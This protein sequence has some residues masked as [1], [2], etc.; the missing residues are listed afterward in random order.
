MLLDPIS[1]DQTNKDLGGVTVT[2]QKPF[3]ETKIDRTVVN[4]D[5]S[6]TSVGAT[7]LDILEKSPGIMVNHD[8]LISL[9]GK[10]GVIVMMDGKQTFLSPADLTNLLRNTPAS[11]LDQI[12]I[13]TNPSSKFD[14]AGNS[15]IINI[16]TKK[17]RAAGF[18][19]SVM[20]GATTSIYNLDGKTLFIPKSQ[21]SI[22]FNY[23]KNKINFFG[24]YN[25]NFFRGRNTMH[26]DT[27]FLNND[28]ELT[29]YGTTDTRFIF[30]GDNHTL[31]LGLDVF[32]NK[33][34]V[35]GV[36]VSGFTF[37]GRPKPTTVAD[38]FSATGQLENR[39]VSFTE[40]Q[41]R[42][43]NFTGNA[44]WK[45]NFDSVGKELTMDF[46]YVKYSSETDM[47]LTTNY[48]DGNLQST[49]R[50]F[51]KGNLPSEIDIYS[52][53]T[54]FVM[55][56]K[57]GRFEAGVKISYV[58]ND[59]LVDYERSFDEQTWERDNIRSNHFIYKE[60]INAG[61]VT[62]NKKIKKWTVQGGLRV[63]N[64]I[65]EGHQIISNTKFRR[66]TTNFFPTAFVSYALSDKNTFTVNYGRR[67]TRPNYQDLNPFIFFL[68]TLSYRK[69]NIYLKPQ[70]THNVE[71]THAF[72]GKFITTLNYNHTDNV[73]SQIVKPESGFSKIRFLTV[74]NVASFR[75]IGIAL[76]TPVTIAEWW[77]TNIF[78]NVFNNRFKGVVDTFAVDVAFTSF[79]INV[80]N[81]FTIAKGF[82]AELSGF[83]RHKGLN[84]LSIAEPV[85]QMGFGLQKQIMKTKG[86]IRLNVRDPFAW[87]VFRGL[88]KY[89]LTDADY[90]IRP[91]IRQVTAT[92]TWRFGGNGQNNQPRRRA[93]S[94]EDEQGR[95]GQGNQ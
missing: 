80:T 79:S 6:P 37:L 17:G 21:N 20:I 8:G 11:A 77:N 70:L 84:N 44:N 29:G 67:I 22:N 61:Y 50:T 35:F 41:F 32:A 78:T 62:Y 2:A 36:V 10:E 49:G 88:N 66:D 55:P 27:R 26:F 65:G 15:G 24:N 93:G 33:K 47:V 76:T 9:R 74:D 16:K 53:K 51:L 13:M 64:T 94:S 59:N 48:Y 40:N 95:A 42:F 23:R 3:V 71:L 12:E 1:V 30:R 72:K 45:H 90:S 82:T 52:F 28:K 92:F 39:L 68:D 46:D 14:A 38:L 54:D 5:E 83:Y 31:K 25:P 58:N 69:G 85:Y 18:N 63:E 57:D 87:Q 34:N 89:G 7:A 75:N 91:D 60:N 4:V 43:K 73:I 86:T 56:V 19:G 81:N